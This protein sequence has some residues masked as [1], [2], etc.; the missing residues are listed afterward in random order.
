M[1]FLSFKQGPTPGT[2]V[3]IDGRL[4]GLIEGQSG[5]PGDLLTIIRA[6]KAAVSSAHETLARAP[7]LDP[8]TVSFEP[9]VR[10]SSKI[11]C[12]GQNYRQH[13]LE[14]GNPI[15][16]YPVIFVRFQS[17]LVGHG[18][19]IVRPTASI[20]LDYEAELA[21]VIGRRVR[22]ATQETALEAVAGYSIFNDASVRDF[23]MRTSQFTM[24]KNFDATG[25]FGPL[26]VT[27]D[28]LPAGG[29]PLRM[30][31]RLNGRTMQST[32]T[33]DMIFDVPTLITV[34]SEVMTLEPGDV[35]ITGTPSGVGKARK[36]SVF[37][38]PGDVCEVEIEKIGILR[39][40]VVQES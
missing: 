7:E 32:L 1:R 34:L 4:S 17:T 25:A 30:E 28:E 22:H 37:L 23:Q 19:A 15:P 33:D 14:M 6:G 36:P 27:P 24:G 31:L 40:P 8:A 26:L 18:G 10:G 35:I 29:S 21:V 12:V 3:S 39:N 2:G 11:L 20:E 38:A 16:D 13:A 9:P 5:Y